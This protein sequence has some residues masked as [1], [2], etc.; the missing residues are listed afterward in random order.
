MS[1]EWFWEYGVVILFYL[2]VIALIYFNRKKFVFEGIIAMYRTKLGL[3]QMDSFSKPLSKK[4]DRVGA[5]IFWIS[6]IPLTI[7]GVLLIPEILGLQFL[8]ETAVFFKITF[9]VSALLL[10]VAT[11]C[12]RQI[13]KAG[14]VGVVVGYLGMVAML[15]MILTGMEQLIFEPDAPALLTPVLPGIPIPGSPIKLPLVEGLIAL[16]AVVV[17]HEFS[18]GVLARA[19]KMKIKSSGFVMMGPIPGAF[20][21]PDEKQ[22][23]KAKKKAQLAVFAAGPFSNMLLTAF[24]IIVLNLLALISFSAYHSEG[25]LVTGFLNE[26]ELAEGGRLEGISQGM[27]ISSVDGFDVADTGDLLLG[28]E[29]K[30]P[31]DTVT[32]GFAD[33]EKNVV[34]SANP[35]NE[36]LPYIGIYLKNNVVAKNEGGFASALQGV[37]FWFAGNPWG[38]SINDRLGLLGWINVLSLGI[39]LVNLLPI[40]PTDGGRM[41]LLALERYMKKKKAKKVWSATAIVLLVFI[42][43]LV[44]VPIIRAIFF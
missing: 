24:L 8:G 23:S 1:A 2:G 32:I 34:L 13:K 6:V 33:G 7:S 9:L 18:H 42:V 39:G 4:K 25:V 3:K 37:Y 10:I 22:L 5:W 12:F 21:E 41:Y 43:V 35:D 11:I 40:G 38:G 26:S 27:I 14:I 19:Y 44:F 28:L 17:I 16:F 31:G 29:N 15:A 30:S 20:V 36:S